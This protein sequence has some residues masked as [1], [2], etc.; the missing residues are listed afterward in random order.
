MLDK[1]LVLS[2]IVGFCLALEVTTQVPQANCDEALPCDPSLC[3]LPDCSCSG[4]EINIANNAER[5]QI[6]YLTYDD[7]FTAYAEENYYRGI[8]DGT[9]KN[10]DGNTIRATHFLTAQYTDYTLVHDYWAMGHEMASHSITHRTDMNYWKGLNVDGWS[11]EI[12]GMRKLIT[13]FAAIPKADVKGYR[14]PFLQMGAD[15]QFAALK[16]DGFL[17]DCSWVS[18]DYGYLDLDQGLFPYSMDYESVQD[19]PIE[20]CP[21]CGF[22]GLWVQPML[23]LEDNWIGANPNLPDNGMPCSMLDG[24]I[25]MDENPTRDTVKQMLMKNFN[26]NR[27]GTRAPMGLYMHAAWFASEELIWHYDGYKDFLQEVTTTYDDVWI[28]P[29]VDGLDYYRNY[30]NF[31]NSDI[32]ALGEDGPFSP[33]KYASRPSRVCEALAPCTYDDV[34]NEDIHGGQRIMHICKKKVNGQNQSCPDEYPWLTNSCGGNTPC[35]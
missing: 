30:N 31:T 17:Y 14:S 4:A 11:Q 6:I 10:P 19:C 28:V 26:R 33:K 2:V 27:A 34:Q 18:R 32:L 16:A 7:A 1:A 25:I 12:S 23:D 13:Q 24:C 8:F 22:E 5:P 29:I 3:V 9:F 20:P 15:E 21:T 35:A